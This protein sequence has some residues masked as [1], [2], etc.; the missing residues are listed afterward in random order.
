MYIPIH[1][2]SVYKFLWGIY[3]Y[4]LVVLLRALSPL[5][6]SPTSK[7]ISFLK[8]PRQT[9]MASSKKNTSR[10]A[11]SAAMKAKSPADRGAGPTDGHPSHPLFSSKTSKRV[12]LSHIPTWEKRRTGM[13]PNF[14]PK[15]SSSICSPTSRNRWTSEERKRTM[16]ARSCSRK[17]CGGP[18]PQPI[19]HS[20]WDPSE[21]AVH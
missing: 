11:T 8:K 12:S 15:V 6:S 5:Q 17:R 14:P 21:I 7:P 13:R 9:K 20:N 19:I 10:A 18:H 1:N 3:L 16:N 2:L 4:I